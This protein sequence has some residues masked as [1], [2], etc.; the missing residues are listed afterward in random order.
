MVYEHEKKEKLKKLE[1][2]AVWRERKI[3]FGAVS[4]FI[5]IMPYLVHLCVNGIQP[6]QTQDLWYS[7]QTI[8]VIVGENKE[9]IFL[10]SYLVGALARCATADYGEEALKAIAVVLRSNAVCTILEEGAVLRS[11]F[12]TDD[13]LKILW[14]KDYE[15]NLQYFRNAVES[16]RGIVIFYR[17]EIVR[18]PYHKVSAGVTRESGIGEAIPYLTSVESSEDMYGDEYYKIIEI[19]KKVLGEKF[20]IKTMDAYG[21]VL[22]VQLGEM[23]MSG[24]AFRKEY[25]LPSACFEYE[26]R[27]DAHF[28]YV[29]GVGHG[30]GLS[31]YGANALSQ[32]GR[33]FA[34]ILEYYYK[35]IEIRKE[36]RSDIVA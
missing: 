12:Y 13:E 11:S 28:F 3:L 23:E 25:G 30:Y 26:E 2:E 20:I 6:A 16:T 31:L 33:S 24:E 4:F 22:R 19:S 27:E 9:N 18:V 32:K 15:A 34:E 5:F 7:N 8:Q 36:N 14:G 21:Y 1:K 10:E 17:G 29:R 35:E